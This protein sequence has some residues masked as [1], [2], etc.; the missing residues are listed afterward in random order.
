[1]GAGGCIYRLKWMDLDD[2][3]WN[4]MPPLLF[5]DGLIDHLFSRCTTPCPS[6]PIQPN[7]FHPHSKPV[8]GQLKSYQFIESQSPQTS[9][10][11]PSVHLSSNIITVDPFHIYR[12]CEVH[13]ESDRSATQRQFA[14]PKSVPPA[15]LWVCK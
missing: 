14:M 8:S 1:M 5:H 9:T 6:I 7:P 10:T 11:T 2:T 3:M 4:W 15:C 12:F 13:A